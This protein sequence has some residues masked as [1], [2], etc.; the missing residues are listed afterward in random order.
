MVKHASLF[1]SIPLPEFAA[2]KQ[3]IVHLMGAQRH[4]LQDEQVNEICHRTDGYSCADMT[5]L[6]KE[7]AFGPIRSISLEDI[8][9]ITADQASYFYN[10]SVK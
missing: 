3:I 8:E 9:F 2:R 1:N 4:N 5:N 10:A 7:A 6:C